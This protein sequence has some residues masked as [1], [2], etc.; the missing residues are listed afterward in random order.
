MKVAVKAAVIGAAQVHSE[1]TA[2]EVLLC[3]V[4]AV[5]KTSSTVHGAVVVPDGR[6]VVALPLATFV[7]LTV[8]DTH[9]KQY[10]RVW[11]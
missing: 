7:V 10:V 11:S 5:V 2:V 4:S 1:T 8:K 3:L 6:T 9:H